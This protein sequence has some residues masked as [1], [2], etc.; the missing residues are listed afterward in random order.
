[1]ELYQNGDVDVL[2]ATD[3]IGMG[4]NLDI[5][6]VAFSGLRK[7]DGRRM[8]DL[9]PHE[10]AQIA[11][12]AG[13]HTNAGTFGVTGEA[14]PL[15]PG[16]AEAI[17]EHRF[18]PVKRLWWRNS[19]LEFGSVARL[20]AS[21]EERTDDEWLTRGREADDLMALK[22]LAER[23]E[24]ATRIADARDVRLLWDVCRIP[25]F[26]GISHAEHADLLG[27]IFGFLHDGGRVPDD[28]LARQVRG[29][30]EPTATSTRC[31]SGWHIS[32]HGPTW[33]SARAG[34]RTKAIGAGRP[35][36]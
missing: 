5:K 24:V 8:R 21:L 7:F 12:R 19:D 10:L 11:G 2:V 22:A 1:V 4:L 3:A 26:R 32:A 36:P 17:M 29:S 9:M 31:P 25:D 30:I 27:R 13:R 20:I 23:E 16:V 33:R 35:V 14:P 6:H 34:W 15:D 28:W 18:A